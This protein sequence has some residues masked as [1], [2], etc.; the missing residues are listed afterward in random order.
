MFS[1]AVG[2]EASTLCGEKK[3]K[4]DCVLE[5]LF[6]PLRQVLHGVSAGSLRILVFSVFK[7]VTVIA[8]CVTR[9]WKGL[10]GIIQLRK[11]L[12][13]SPQ[14]SFLFFYMSGNRTSKTSFPS[15]FVLFRERRRDNWS[16]LS[17]THLHGC[18]RFAKYQKEDKN[19]VIYGDKEIREHKRH[20]EHTFL[21]HI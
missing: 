6:K 9:V 1:A 12:F 8:I 11:P 15:L 7:T 14:I 19:K 4:N 20:I 17:S 5:G 3:K 13:L 18:G 2:A 10:S 21:D 16:A